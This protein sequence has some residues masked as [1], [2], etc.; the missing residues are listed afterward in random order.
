[1]ASSDGALKRELWYQ[2]EIFAL[3]GFAFAQPILDV[4]GRHLEAFVFRGAGRAEIVLFAFAVTFGPW[5]AIGI[6]AAL[7][8]LAGATI[9]RW[10]QLVV[11]A[12]L[13]GLVAVHV[14]KQTTDLRGTVLAAAAAIGIGFS[15]AYERFRQVGLWARYA[16][17]APVVFLVL[18]LVVSPTASLVFPSEA[19][20]ANI[21][22][23]KLPRHIV[24][25]LFDEFPTESIVGQDAQID[26]TRFP[27]LAKLA[28]GSTWYRNYTSVSGSTQFAVPSLLSGGYPKN[29]LATA[30][31]YPHN[32]F[33]LLGSGYE[34][35]AG[36]VITALCPQSVCQQRSAGTPALRNLTKD[37]LDIYRQQVSLSDSHQQVEA[38]FVEETQTDEQIAQSGGKAKNAFDVLSENASS[39]P[40]RMDEFLN[41]IRTD[42]PTLEFV[43]L[44]LPHQPWHFYPSGLQYPHPGQDPGLHVFITG[45]WGDE[46]RPAE[47]GR[48]RHLLQAQYVDGLVG[49]VVADLKQRG[50]Y[51]DSLLVVTADHGAAFTP[52]EELRPGIASDQF[53][54]KT[55]DQIMWAPLLIKAPNQHQGVV[56]DVNMESIDLLPTI[57][58]M[59]GVRLPWK[60]DGIPVSKPRHTSQKVFVTSKTVAFKSISLGRHYTVDGRTGFQ[61]MLAGNEGG[62]AP[63][64]DAKW[65]FYKVGPYASIVGRRVDGLTV[66]SA[67]PLDVKVQNADAF[68]NVD[69]GS[70]T[71]PGLLL[72]NP[73][74]DAT[75][76]VAVNG[77]IA[78]VSATFKGQ[79]QERLLGVIIPDFLFTKGK[80]DVRLFSVEKN[81]ATAVLHPL[82]G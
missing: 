33:T 7:T 74:S 41:G 80:N 60:V 72:A 14:V 5:L 28:S 54:A 29:E 32:L 59:V 42:R 52:G 56:S 66:G 23:S 38:G 71:V 68:A 46:A 43:H 82:A 15:V 4:F 67:S 3:C 69:P 11:L 73:E 53:P 63:S 35:H 50:I 47:L 48:Q 16:S 55:Y 45:S 61:Q 2:L 57:A 31:N 13:A 75:V 24:F 79:N 20:A 27:N 25:V 19:R 30:A 26:A 77:T 44:L 64:G 36:E 49:Q 62:F 1:M 10:V 6:G 21:E 9:R 65:A 39:S 37:A 78:G 81:G 51:D 58:D 22:G 8:R 17:V 40:A 34:V 76:A 70:G 12:G 18:F